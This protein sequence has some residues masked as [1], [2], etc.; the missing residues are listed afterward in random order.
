MLDDLKESAEAP[1]CPTCSII[2][3]AVD[4]MIGA[5][6]IRVF[7]RLE[8]KRK[9]EPSKGPL[10]VDLLPRYRGDT[11]SVKLQLFIRNGE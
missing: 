10:R 11:R 7:D 3:H 4:G 6:A 5:Y 9:K 2:W 8:I 1:G